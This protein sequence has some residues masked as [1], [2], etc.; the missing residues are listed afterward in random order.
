PGAEQV[1][2]MALALLAGDD[3]DAVGL[4]LE[5]PALRCGLGR[6]AAPLT[7]DH[8][9]PPHCWSW[10]RARPRCRESTRLRRLCFP[11][12][13]DRAHVRQVNSAGPARRSR[14]AGAG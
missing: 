11:T 13:N 4:D 9:W 7:S 2:R 5:Q 8:V 14:P 3:V 10:R 12:E 1:P 6:F